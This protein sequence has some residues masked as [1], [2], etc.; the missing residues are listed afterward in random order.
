VPKKK[1]DSNFLKLKK[2][3]KKHNIAI[4]NGEVQL[5]IQTGKKIIALQKKMKIG[6][7]ADF[8]HLSEIKI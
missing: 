7:I 1:K 6:Y 3:W 4:G 5:A 8:S 2:L